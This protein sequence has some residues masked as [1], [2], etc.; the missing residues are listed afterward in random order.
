MIV[1]I[2]ES[3]IFLISLDIF[4]F[5]VFNPVFFIGGWLIRSYIQTFF[6]LLLFSLHISSAIASLL[7]KHAKS[8]NY[9]IFAT[10]A[11][12]H[13]VK[14]CEGLENGTYSIK[15]G[16]Y[17]Q[18][19]TAEIIFRFIYLF[20][21]YISTEDFNSV[22]YTIIC[23]LTESM[24]YYFAKYKLF[25]IFVAITT[26]ITT[27]LVARINC[28][29]LGVAFNIINYSIILI[30]DWFTYHIDLTNPHYIDGD[31]YHVV[32]GNLAL[33]EKH[34]RNEVFPKQI[35]LMDHIFEIKIYC[36]SFLEEYTRDTIIFEEDNISNFVLDNCNQYITKIGLPRVNSEVFHYFMKYFPNLKDVETNDKNVLVDSKY[37]FIIHPF[38]LLFANRR[39]RLIQI[40]EGIKNI[41][42]SS[43][44]GLK[45]IRSVSLPNSCRTICSKAFADC[46]NL[47]HVRMK[48]TCIQI[49][50]HG[51]FKRCALR[52]IVFPATLQVI[53]K[54][55]FYFCSNLR[56]VEFQYLS[57]L[58]I[59]DDKAFFNTAIKRLEIPLS[60][61]LIG[62]SAFAN[63]LNLT[64]V[65]FAGGSNIEI[66]DEAFSNTSVNNLIIPINVK[67]IGKSAF[68][69]N[70][71]LTCVELAEGSNIKIGCNAFSYTSIRKLVIPSTW[72]KIDSHAFSYISC[73]SELVFM[74]PST[75]EIIDNSSFYFSGLKK[76]VMPS[77]V[78]LIE[79]QAFG[80]NFNLENVI[81]MKESKLI[82]LADS[83]FNGCKKIKFITAEERVISILNF[84]VIIRL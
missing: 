7:S 70:K 3:E 82:K 4:F 34:N 65:D 17:V 58:R 12:I 1:L 18:F 35:E 14:Y 76:L 28:F 63:N 53:D 50:G 20:I 69:N 62:K 38:T 24:L 2:I 39:S 75:V 54:K 16:R 21:Y 80:N 45:N 61:T 74:S 25:Y 43:C 51:A 23:I 67:S 66:G 19:Y 8:G 60:V 83:A 31:R 29:W 81:F 47:R 52:S 30:S 33:V 71:K 11:M 37:M 6:S 72:R 78:K 5:Y 10:F 15:R 49:I 59:I 13:V 9:L 56:L 55:A 77:S 48:N 68:A 57:D 32:D 46:N 84:P 79:S 42:I 26:M 73:L 27:T 64:S 41:G 40:R 36:N 22:K 44:E